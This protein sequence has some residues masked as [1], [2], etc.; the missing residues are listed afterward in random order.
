[1]ELGKEMLSN[2]QDDSRPVDQQA[3]V[4]RL[5]SLLSPLKPLGFRKIRV[6]GAADGGYVMIDDFP[7][8]PICYSLGI[9]G[10]V[11]WDL[12]MAARGA[13]VYQYDHTIQRPP[14][15]HPAFHFFRLGIGDGEADPRMTTLAAALTKNGHQDARDLILKM[16]IE[17]SEW[18]VLEATPESCLPGFS[19]IVI[20]YHGLARAADKF[21]IAQAEKILRKMRRTHMP[22]HVHGNNWGSYP[23]LYGVP[24]PDVL[25]VTYASRAAYTFGATDEIFPTA[26]DRPCKTGLAD[27]YLGNFRF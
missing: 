24:V 5:L 1:M 12:A 7:A 2:I 25:E 15:D 10:D 4:V 9:G 3:R 6:G 11:S 26:L 18:S 16:D 23:L 21:W 13:T 22:V 27:L 19:Q 14:T 20:E 8:K 17:D